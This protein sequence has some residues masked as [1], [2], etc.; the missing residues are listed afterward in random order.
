MGKKDDAQTEEIKKTVTLKGLKKNGK[1]HEFGMK[2]ALALLR[3]QKTSPVKGW[4]ISDANYEF[5]DNEI[6]RKSSN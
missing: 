1:E 3:L 5:K 6:I 2:H 4:E